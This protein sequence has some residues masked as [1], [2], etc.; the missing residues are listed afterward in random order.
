MLVDVRCVGKLVLGANLVLAK[1]NCYLLILAFY[2]CQTFFYF[3]FEF[4]PSS[5]SMVDLSTRNNN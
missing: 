2:S 4:L 1:G 3:L 5:S